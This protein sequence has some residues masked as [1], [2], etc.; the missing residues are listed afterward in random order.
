MGQSS[1]SVKRF[2]LS[3]VAHLNGLLAANQLPAS[4]DAFTEEINASNIQVLTQDMIYL[5]ELERCHLGGFFDPLSQLF[6]SLLELMPIIN[7]L[8]SASPIRRVGKLFY[9]KQSIH[10]IAADIR[11][12]LDGCLNNQILRR[13]W[14]NGHKTKERFE[15]ESVLFYWLDYLQRLVEKFDGY[16]KNLSIDWLNDKLTRLQQLLIEVRVNDQD[17]SLLSKD[18]TWI[19]TSRIDTPKVDATLPVNWHEILGSSV[20]SIREQ[21][22]RQHMTSVLLRDV[23]FSVIGFLAVGYS[24]RALPW[25]SDLLNFLMITI[26]NEYIAY[27]MSISVSAYNQSLFPLR[28]LI[29]TNVSKDFEYNLREGVITLLNDTSTPQCYLD[30]KQLIIETLFYLSENVTPEHGPWYVL[31]VKLVSQFLHQQDDDAVGDSVVFGVSPK[32]SRPVTLF[33]KA[34]IQELD[35]LHK[36]NESG[37]CSQSIKK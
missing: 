25:L 2:R 4:S 8:V 18:I 11:K 12:S 17:L 37:G 19:D 20:S 3:L 7:M 24:E 22:K 33:Q 21:Q 5:L 15:L 31:M 34:C 36:H 13:D 23:I 29:H 32:V 6:Q 14:F 35:S 10:R 16:L 30:K 1:Y 27:M 9:Q 26:V 28:P